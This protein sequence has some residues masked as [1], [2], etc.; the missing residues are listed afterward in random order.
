LGPDD[1]EALL[2]AAISGR[3]ATSRALTISFVRALFRFAYNDNQRLISAPVLF[4]EAFRSP[5]L[6]RGNL[7]RPRGELKMFTAAQLQKVLAFV[8]RP[9]KAMFLLG[10]NCGLGNH[11]IASLTFDNLDLENGWHTHPR[12]KTGM[13]RR[14]PL[15]PETIEAIEHALKIRPRPKDPAHKDL[16][17]LT[18][19]GLPYT[20]LSA[21]SA[22]ALA[23]GKAEDIQHE[24]IIN[25]N[26]WA[27]LKRLKMKRDGLSFYAL[28]HTFETIGGGAKDQIAVD[29]IMGHQSP[30]M[31]TNYRQMIEDDRLQAVVDHV[32]RWLWP[33]AGTKE[34]K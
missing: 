22:V 30:G 13:P 18:R 14:C 11:D 21:A 33:V 12:P 27:I 10:I 15:W 31:G 2:R 1:F 17:F 26:T 20:R 24:D 32:R 3:A 8:K 19:N 16:V 4:G 6:S 7:D 28:R 23:E 25:T 29:Y 9:M 34:G 5:R